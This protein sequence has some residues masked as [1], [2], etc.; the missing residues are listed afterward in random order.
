MK[1]INFND[2]LDNTIMFYG[3][4][5]L[6]DEFH[7]KSEWLRD[8]GL[9]DMKIIGDDYTWHTACINAAHIDLNDILEYCGADMHEAWDD[10]VW[11]DAKDDPVIKAGIDRIN[12]VF[13]EYP[14]YWENELVIF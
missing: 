5:E 1:K 12:E 11:H 10:S 9:E 8:I 14:S 13:A 2:I 4:I 6:C 3:D 7:T